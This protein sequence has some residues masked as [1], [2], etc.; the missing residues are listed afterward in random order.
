MIVG[1]ELFCCKVDKIGYVII[2]LLII[3]VIGK[4]FGKLEGNVVWFNFE[5]IFLYEM[6]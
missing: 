3:D 2:V 5:K 4:K 1:I 6:Y